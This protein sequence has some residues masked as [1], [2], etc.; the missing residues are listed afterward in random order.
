MYLIE[1]GPI[2]SRF[3]HN[4]LNMF[5]KHIDAKISRFQNQY[6]AE[7][8]RLNKEG[9]AIP[10]TLEPDAVVP[11]ILYALENSKPKARYFVTFPTHLFA[12]LNS[13][14]PTKILDHVLISASILKR[15]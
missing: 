15:E 10:F 13:I 7:D 2:T 1:P 4:S 3:R 11:K 5:Y 8:K 6:K 14:L 9:Q 12:A